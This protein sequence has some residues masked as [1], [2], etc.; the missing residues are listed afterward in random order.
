MTEAE[1]HLARSRA[2]P[3]V[4]QRMGAAPGAGPNDMAADPCA[5]FPWRRTCASGT[6]LGL[7]G[8]GR[9]VSAG[10]GRNAF[11]RGEK[12]RHLPTKPLREVRPWPSE[13]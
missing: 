13:P 12:P 10:Q 5:E 9:K 3:M 11:D 1:A 2:T 8:S 6:G 7:A 4:I